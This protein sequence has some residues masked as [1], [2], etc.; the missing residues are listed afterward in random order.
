MEYWQANPRSLNNKHL[1]QLHEALHASVVNLL[2]SVWYKIVTHK[3]EGYTDHNRREL[4]GWKLAAVDLAPVLIDDIS[5]GDARNLEKVKPRTRGYAYGWLKKNH[6]R[7]MDQA[8][9]IASEMEPGP[10]E[11]INHNGDLYWRKK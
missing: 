11:L 5:P 8:N 10:G 4:K 1:L 3:I 7:I 2:G 9:L 6:K